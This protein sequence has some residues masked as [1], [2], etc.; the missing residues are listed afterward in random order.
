MDVVQERASLIV[1]ASRLARELSGILNRAEALGAGLD[2]RI[3][4]GPQGPSGEWKILVTTR[5]KP[6]ADLK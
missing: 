1:D 6:E 3:E 2:V 5:R 4:R